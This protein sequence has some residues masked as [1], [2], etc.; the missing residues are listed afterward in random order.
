MDSGLHAEPSDQVWEDNDVDTFEIKVDNV[1]ITEDEDVQRIDTRPK[2]DGPAWKTSEEE[3]NIQTAEP[4]GKK[5]Y[6]A[7]VHHEKKA[8]TKDT[9]NFPD[10]NRPEASASDETS[11]K[12]DGQKQTKDSKSSNNRFEG[13]DEEA[14]V[15]DPEE[16]KPE[17]P[18]KKEA[19]KPREKGKKGKAKWKQMDAK[20]SVATT[21]LD[22]QTNVFQVVEEKEVVVTY[23]DRPKQ[24]KS[25]PFAKPGTEGIFRNFDNKPRAVEQSAFAP[26]ATE[27]GVRFSRPRPEAAE[28]GVRFARAKP[29]NAEEGVRFSRPKQES[30]FPPR[31]SE[32]TTKP[33]AWRNADGVKKDEDTVGEAHGE[34]PKRRFFNKSKGNTNIDPLKPQEEA[35]KTPAEDVWGD[36]V[37]PPK[38][39]AWKK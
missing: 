31:N 17:E 7:S 4:V 33:I 9:Q 18:K 5:S 24:E 28:E 11:A 13:L 30:N 36:N 32:D 29:E 26:K 22:S 39:N 2:R 35:K 21:E 27:E 20:L 23:S 38:Q 3:P 1:E 15:L 12:K 34:A 10:I 16:T 25:F 37:K 6:R 8:P 19:K 14:P